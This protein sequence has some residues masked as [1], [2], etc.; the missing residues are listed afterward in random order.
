MMSPIM[1]LSEDATKPVSDIMLHSEVATV[2]NIFVFR[3]DRL[4]LIASCSTVPR[5]ELKIGD[6]VSLSAE[7]N[8]HLDIIII[9]PLLSDCSCSA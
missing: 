8:Y 2:L 5:R 1:L 9:C 7:G 3:T 4:R 6:A